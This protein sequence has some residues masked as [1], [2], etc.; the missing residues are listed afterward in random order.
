MCVC[1]RCDGRGSWLCLR[2]KVVLEHFNWFSVAVVTSDTAVRDRRRILQRLTT[3]ELQVHIHNNNTIVYT[4]LYRL[5]LYR[6]WCALMLWP[7]AWT[8]LSVAG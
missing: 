6:F 3:G 2:L 7:G 5:P 8:C 4:L 1:E